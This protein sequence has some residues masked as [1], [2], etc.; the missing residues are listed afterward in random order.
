MTSLLSEDL[1]LS[2]PCCEGVAL[3]HFVSRSSDIVIS[4]MPLPT[5]KPATKVGDLLIAGKNAMK[6]LKRKREPVSLPD[7]YAPGRYDVLSG[8]SHNN[9]RHVGNRR[10]RVIIENHAAAFAAKSTKSGRSMMIV[11]ILKTV[12]SAG[13]VFIAKN[14]QD[15]WDT[16]TLVKS[17]EKIGR[18][19]RAA[20]VAMTAN[21]E[22]TIYDVIGL[23]DA[24]LSIP[25]IS[26]QVVYKC[27]EEVPF[28]NLDAEIIDSFSSKK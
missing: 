25:E 2:H 22:R 3:S 20:I 17:K 6:T 16:V 12:E 5:T 23:D 24:P 27:E 9:F 26:P 15:Q 18:A 7:G 21:K 14:E 19:L 13:G 10:F 4:S 8:R 28:D 11:S 1:A